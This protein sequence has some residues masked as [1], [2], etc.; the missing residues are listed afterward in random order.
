MRWQSLPTAGKTARLAALEVLE[1]LTPPQAAPEVLALCQE[2]DV[3]IAVRALT[4]APAYPQPRT[5]EV[6]TRLLA[7]GA[8][9]ARRAAA[10]SLARLNG[11]G[12][13]AG[14]TTTSASA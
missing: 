8:P 9:E 3:E 10:E 12:H 1:R 13:T 4:V 14:C 11:S 2:Q 6:L 7:G 5:L